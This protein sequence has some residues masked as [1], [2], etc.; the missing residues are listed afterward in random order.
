M[1]QVFLQAF[2]MQL[3]KSDL[4]KIKILEVAIKLIATKGI[5]SCSFELIGKQLKM[6]KAN[7]AYYFNGKDD[8]IES[9]VRWIAAQAQIY[10]QDGMGK[11]VEKSPSEINNKEIIRHYVKLTYQWLDEF[12]WHSS[13]MLY[14]LSTCVHRPIFKR[15]H[16]E[17]RSQNNRRIAELLAM[18]NSSLKAGDRL[19]LAANINALI[20][21]SITNYLT[22]D[23]DNI[24]GYK[25]ARKGV[26]RL[27][28]TYVE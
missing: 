19:Q 24:F 28:Q 1:D 4:K 11:V 3:K 2:G 6:T 13:V 8:L 9:V 12:P 14:F 21:G 10:T 22:T 26:E 17:I 18:E 5:E 23:M 15:I 16:S 20:V 25:S 7:V 27:L